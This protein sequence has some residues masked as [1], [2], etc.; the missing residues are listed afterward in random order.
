MNITH[1]LRAE[2][3]LPNTLRQVRTCSARMGHVSAESRVDIPRCKSVLWALPTKRSRE[4]VILAQAPCAALLSGRELC[5]CCACADSFMPS[6]ML[7]TRA[8]DNPS[9]GFTAPQPSHTSPTL[10]SH[11]QLT[12]SPPPPSRQHLMLS[13]RSWPLPCTFQ[14]PLLGQAAQCRPC[15]AGSHLLRPGL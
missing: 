5:R 3:H 7:P 6:C 9:H 11:F 12:R 1:V 13:R 8:A 14:M 2:E 10:R 4:A 15:R